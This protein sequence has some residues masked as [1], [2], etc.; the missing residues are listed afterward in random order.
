MVLDLQ[1]QS[2]TCSQY[3]TCL[4]TSTPAEVDMRV[5]WVVAYAPAQ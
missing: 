5:G 4:D 3:N 2:L 1:S